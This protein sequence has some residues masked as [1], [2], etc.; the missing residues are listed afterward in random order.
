M[1]KT[2]TIKS[3]IKNQIKIYYMQ[4]KLK[5]MIEEKTIQQNPLEKCL[6]LNIIITI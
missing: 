3:I 2:V 4:E 6:I 1:M 5:I